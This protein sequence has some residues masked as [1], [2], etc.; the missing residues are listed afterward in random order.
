MKVYVDSIGVFAP[1][2]ANWPQALSVFCGEQ[3]L[4][5]HAQLPAFNMAD[6]PATERRRA[7]KSV[8]LAVDLAAQAMASAFIDPT[9]PAAVFAS[10]SGD[11]EVLTDI[12]AAL[13]TNDRLISPMRFHNSV[14][15]AASGYWTIAQQNRQ[16]ATAVAL[17][18]L[19]ASAGLLEAATQVVS[20]NIPVLL[21]IYDM[22]FPPPLDAA[23]PIAAMFG[24]S[25]LLQPARTP[26][27]MA[28]LS[29]S[30][31]VAESQTV[32]VM[33]NLELEALRTGVAAARGLPLLAALAS[34]LASGNAQT[35]V[36][37]YVSPQVLTIAV[38]PIISGEPNT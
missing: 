15:N 14:H 13:A 36:L 17:H 37:D 10:T 35:V 29:I 6:L 32:N 2:I 24:M 1:G 28:Q 11:T 25:F 20:E 3:P 18:N 12:C 23:E 7:G 22:P 9:L 21:V 38:Q 31:S 4:D 27:S 33:A 16:P 5:I 19:T 26:H 30:L 8:K 34:G